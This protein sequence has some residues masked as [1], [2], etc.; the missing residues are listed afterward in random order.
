MVI[1][2]PL[3]RIVARCLEKRPDAR[4]QSASDSAFA[5]D[6]VSISETLTGAALP[7]TPGARTPGRRIALGGLAGLAVLALTVIGYLAGMRAEPQSSAPIVPGVHRLTGLVGLEEAPAMSPDGKSGGLHVRHWRRAADLRAMHCL[8]PI[9]STHACAGRS[10]ASPLDRRLERNR[11]LLSRGTRRR[12]GSALGSLGARRSSPP[13]HGQSRWGRPQPA[14]RAPGL[15]QIAEHGGGPGHL[16]ER[17]LRRA[18]NRQA[19]VRQLL[20]VSALV[21]RCEVD[22]IS[23]RRRCQVRRLRNRCCR[24]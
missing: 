19:S 13:R 20:L 18:H 4:F 23:A 10:P 9:A 7:P 24:R 3:A 11:L 21:A 5:L 6:T 14:E 1:P 12:A 8:R 16:V 2:R 15:F 17:W 22:C